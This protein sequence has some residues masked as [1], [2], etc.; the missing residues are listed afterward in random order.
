MVIKM[1]FQRASE[2][3]IYFF[4]IVILLFVI[5]SLSAQ[6]QAD[7]VKN[8]LLASLEK[9]TEVRDITTASNV[10]FPEILKGNEEE[11]IPYIEKFSS[12]KR[13]YLSKMYAMG[14]S[15]L[16]KAA[17]ILKKYNL[18]EEL[19]I[20]LVLESEYK[21][22]AVSRAGAVGYWQIMDEVASAY[23]IKYIARLGKVKDAK[24]G[25]KGFYKAVKQRDD[26][27]N[28]NIATHTA[29]RYLRDSKQYVN[30]DW[31][32]VV[33]SYNCGVGRVRKAIRRS[34]KADPTFWDIKK[35]LPAV[36]RNYVMNF[37]TLNVIFNNYE[38]FAKNKLSFASEK[39]MLSEDVENRV[40][41]PSFGYADR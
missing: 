22:N 26:R 1:S 11:M 23:G 34:G 25:E 17:A 15:L 27:K 40:T 6:N 41:E 16:P 5:E 4:I 31:L 2:K 32:M 37:I 7:T 3:F 38:M 35:Y 13:D 18:P 10:V 30:D 39:I 21:G 12:K 8:R 29:A 19:N 20:L 24:T 28:F 9:N 33:A 14:K 36:T